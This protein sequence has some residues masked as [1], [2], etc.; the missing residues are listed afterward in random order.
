MIARSMPSSAEQIGD[1]LGLPRR[2]G[3]IRRPLAPAVARAVDEDDAPVCGEP[4]PEREPDLFEIAA[5]AVQDDDGHSVGGRGF[6]RGKIDDVH[7]QAGDIHKLSRWADE[8]AR[9]VARRRQ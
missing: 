3:G 7:A 5:R 6:A 4:V 2:R 9:S 8:R 1:Q